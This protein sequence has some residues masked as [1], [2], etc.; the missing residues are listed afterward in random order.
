[1]KILM[2]CDFFNETLEYQENLLLKYYRKH[3]FEVTIV[4][5]NLDSAFDYCASKF[6][7]GS[8]TRHS[9]FNGAKVI[10]LGYKYIRFGNRLRRLKDITPILENE[11]PD[12]VFVHDI[13]PNITEVSKYI[14][15]NPSCKMIL[16][17]HADY[18]NSG[19]NWLSLNILHK[20]IR[21]RF[22]L[23]PARKNISKIFPVVPTGFQFL[24]EV[25]GVSF[26]EMEL[27]PLG[28]DYDLARE[29]EKTV[30][31]QSLRESVGISA[32]DFVV[33][34]G[35]KLNEIKQTHLLLEALNATQLDN[36]HVLIVG[37]PDSLNYESRLH[38]FTR[39]NPRFHFAGWLSS[40]DVYRFM[41]ISDIAVFPSSQSI[42]WQQAICMGLPLVVGDSG[43]Q[44]IEYLNGNQSIVSLPSSKIT[45][46]DI[47]KAIVDLRC[48]EK[49]RNDMRAGAIKTAAD[50]L[51]WNELIYRTLQFNA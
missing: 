20:F 31:K 19:K 21:R 17:Y 27:L 14:G 4:C 16:D 39:G 6:E 38:A 7:L 32:S 18:S 22:F 23:N 33:F 36:V 37:K 26:S 42:L 49:L 41:A 44:S 35:G 15:K 12:L 43:G 51:N 40:R 10:K 48:D 8:P 30:D 46:T 2:L 45:T 29:V 25:Y 3:G 13:L 28:G 5:A 50:L 24:N 47:A 9:Y 1:M 11:R 34:T